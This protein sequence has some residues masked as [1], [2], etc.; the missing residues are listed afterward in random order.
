MN[1]S[2]SRCGKSNLKLL[3]FLFRS[4]FFFCAHNIKINT[5]GTL[6]N[7]FFRYD[8]TEYPSVYL[9]FQPGFWQQTLK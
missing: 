9:F 8:Y 2:V 7:A 1:Y 5:F 4:L 6:Q 3:A